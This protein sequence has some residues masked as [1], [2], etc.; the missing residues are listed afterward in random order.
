ML[1]RLLRGERLSNEER[2]LRI[3]PLR[4]VKR[5]STDVLAVDDPHVADALRYIREHACDPCSVDDVLRHVP[6]GRRWLERQFVKSLGRTVGD[7]IL[8][9]RMERAQRLLV[10]GTL[11]MPA[12]AERC[13]FSCGPTLTRA[14]ERALGI[15]PSAYRRKAQNT[16]R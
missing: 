12:I 15:S 13:G 8:R 3:P 2:H 16:P 9:I 11:K 6:T 7:E 4:V 10:S 14:F 5:L 1:D